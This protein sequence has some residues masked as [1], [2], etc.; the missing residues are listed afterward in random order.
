MSI[1]G[2]RPVTCIYLLVSV[3][4][5]HSKKGSE[6]RLVGFDDSVLDGAAGSGVIRLHRP[7]PAQ[8]VV[9]TLDLN[10]MNS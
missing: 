7:R 2:D 5:P 8:I 9:H 4:C 10:C 3:N 6:G 1:R